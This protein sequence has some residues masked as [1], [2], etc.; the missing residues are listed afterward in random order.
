MIE[1]CI[2]YHRETSYDRDDMS[3]HSIDWA[4]QPDVYKRYPGIEPRP[5]PRDM[6][7]PEERLSALLKP[8]VPEAVV[9]N[10][11][12]EDLSKILLLTYTL[13]AEAR[14]P[15]G[16]FHYRS[17][18]SAGAL[19]PTEIYVASAGIK[20]MDDGLYHFAIRQHGL[21][22][23]RSGGLS[24]HI[25]QIIE[26]PP[27]K[28]PVLT[29]LFTAIFFR[30]AWKY[31]ARSY[32]Y[33]LLDTGHVL[34]NLTLALKALRL[35]FT[36]S[37][38]FDDEKVN[39]LL[40]LDGTKEAALAVCRVPGDALP[41]DPGIGPLPQDLR[42]ASR[43][44]DREV[45]YPLIRDFHLA[46]GARAASERKTLQVRHELGM[47]ARSWEAFPRPS[48]W[49]EVMPYPEAL[50]RRRSR[51]NFAKRPLSEDCGQAL[52]EALSCRDSQR[53]STEQAY[54]TGI[55]IGFLSAHGARMES[56]LFLLDIKKG[57]VGM[58]KQGAFLETMSHISLDQKWLSLA[59]I[60]FLFLADL[61]ALDRT[62]GPRGYRYAMMR[63]GRMGERLYI[64]ATAMGLGCCGIG[65]FYD[66]EAAEFLGL[67]GSAALL[68]LVAVGEVKGGRQY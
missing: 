30:S 32:R 34:E 38:D 21:L 62:W 67:K 7:L 27:D 3:G 46:G 56:G 45:E 48:S 59:G 39:H 4:H 50:F 29:F 13:T 51:R 14:Y 44:S 9:H 68:Y 1:T 33:H 57:S 2:Q 24:S 12:A 6:T 35:P 41:S 36:I 22:R 55:S 37:Y 8:R 19:Y 63:A 20:G 10:L 60:Q 47:R 5:L 64:A 15:D 31:R 43:V 65:A 53:A 28:A 26:A 16:E 54:E 40:G 66:R 25:L 11:D 18:A 17:A 49:P 23:L 61:G 58:V 52:F 42:P